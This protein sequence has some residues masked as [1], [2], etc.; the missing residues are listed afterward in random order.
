MI[1]NIATSA[2]SPEPNTSATSPSGFT[3]RESHGSSFTT[4]LSP[5][6]AVSFGGGTAMSCCIRGSSGTT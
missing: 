4:T 2:E 6:C 1:D 3:F 5:I